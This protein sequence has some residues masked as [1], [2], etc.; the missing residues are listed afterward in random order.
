MSFA[1]SFQY[2]HTGK[3]NINFM[4]PKLKQIHLTYGHLQ[5]KYLEHKVIHEAKT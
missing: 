4:S 2:L 3:V 5:N 1:H